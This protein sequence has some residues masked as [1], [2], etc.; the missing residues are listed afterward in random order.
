MMKIP[1][2]L[3]DQLAVRIDELNRSKEMPFE[4]LM[5]KMAKEKARKEGLQEGREEG[6]E[7]GREQGR[8]QGLEQGR[9]E[10]RR[11]VVH[12]LLQ[13]RFG[14]L[15]R[16]A[17]QFLAQACPAELTAL[18]DKILQAGSLDEL[19]QPKQ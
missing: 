5:I 12:K 9:E 17:E 4:N 18:E 19:I 6:R 16:H 7:Q 10:G 11:A 14:P 1:G 8:K 15:P 13:L 3:Q 2:H